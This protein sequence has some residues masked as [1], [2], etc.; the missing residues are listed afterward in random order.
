LVVVRGVEG[1]ADVTEVL[2]LAPVSEEGL[3]E[4]AGDD[5]ATEVPM[6]TLA[7]TLAADT[8]AVTDTAVLLLESA[9]LA[10]ELQLDP[11]EPSLELQL[12]PAEVTAVGF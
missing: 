5:S 3:I 12:D 10:A 7:D 4:P 2:G 11:A 9:E 8:E 6:E 1:G